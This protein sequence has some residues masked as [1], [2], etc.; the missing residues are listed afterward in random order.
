MTSL[1]QERVQVRMGV[2]VADESAGSGQKD[3]LTGSK[4]GEARER[5]VSRGEMLDSMMATHLSIAA[6]AME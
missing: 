1:L 2:S 6:S 5:L 4:K 3:L